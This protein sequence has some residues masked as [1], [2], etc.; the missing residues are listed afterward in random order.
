[1]IDDLDKRFQDLRAQTLSEIIAPGAPEARATVHRRRN[2]AVFAGTGVA[3]A[4]VLLGAGFVLRPDSGVEYVA[5]GPSALPTSE[6]PPS[7]LPSSGGPPVMSEPSGPEY[8]RVEAAGNLL[9]D[10]TRTPTSINATAGVVTSAYEDDMNDMPVDTYTFNFFCVGAG[11]VNVVVK[12]G[13]S[14]DNVL[15]HGTATCAANDPAPLRLTIEQPT[16]GYLRIF[17]VGDAQSNGKAGFAFEFLS[18]T[19]KTTF[20]PSGPPFSFSPSSSAN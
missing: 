9:A 14:G 16:Y 1:M 4:G 20:G 6:V 18:A 2:V 13:D 5:G 12:Q 8:D 19:G 7:A 11:Q 17:A 10:R 15:G 3:V